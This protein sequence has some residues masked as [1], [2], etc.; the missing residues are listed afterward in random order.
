MCV[1]SKSF[2]V[3]EEI[4]ILLVQNFERSL[5][6]RTFSLF[7]PAYRVWAFLAFAMFKNDELTRM[8]VVL[9]PFGQSDGYRQSNVMMCN[10]VTDL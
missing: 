3:I 1:L 6:R 5:T 4:S 7:A 10:E 2:S 8:L 9:Y